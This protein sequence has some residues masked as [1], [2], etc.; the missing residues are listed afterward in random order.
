[1]LHSFFLIFFYSAGNILLVL[2]K[3]H[4]QLI[5]EINL[6]TIIIDIIGF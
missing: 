6:H 2:P 3:H 1:M 4:N 5:N